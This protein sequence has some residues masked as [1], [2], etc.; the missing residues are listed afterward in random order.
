MRLG[1]WL[2][3]SQFALAMASMAYCCIFLS[4]PIHTSLSTLF[5]YTLYTLHTRSIARLACWAGHAH[6]SISIPI[7]FPSWLWPVSESESERERGLFNAAVARQLSIGQ[8]RPTQCNAM[9]GKSRK[10]LNL[11]TDSLSLSLT[12]SLELAYATL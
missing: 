8:R 11:D 3:L 1:H 5:L 2:S 12:L 7:S 4:K 10:I 9:G 6:L